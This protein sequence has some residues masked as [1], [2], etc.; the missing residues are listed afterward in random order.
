MPGADEYRWGANPASNTPSMR[1]CAS[2][3]PSLNPWLLTS[4]GLRGRPPSHSCCY[5]WMK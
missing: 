4:G 1:P 2:Y 5:G 3:A